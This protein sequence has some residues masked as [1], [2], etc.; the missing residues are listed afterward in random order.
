MIN[1]KELF[2]NAYPWQ[3]TMPVLEI[4][5]EPYE[6]GYEYG[7]QC[8]YIINN[9]SLKFINQ[10]AEI[11][12]V[13]I[14][15]LEDESLKYEKEIKSQI[16]EE[17]INEMK[18]IAAGADVDYLDILIL[19]CG[20][21][22]LNSLPTPET[23]PHYMCSSFS[24]YNE[25]TENSNLICG[26]NDDGGR[27]IDQFLVL[28]KVH[29]NNGNSFVAPVVPGYIGYHRMWNSKGTVIFGL[30]LENGCKNEVFDY[31][32]PMWV[33]HRYLIQYK[34][35]TGQ[36]AE[37]LKEFSPPTAFNFLVSD[38]KKEV[39]I[40]HVSA[41]KIVEYKPEETF[42][43]L[44]NHAL[45]DDIKPYV[46]LREHPSSTDYRY[47]T[48]FNHIQNNKGKINVDVG[49]SAL[50]SHNDSSNGK[51]IPSPNTP[52]SHHEY[53]NKMTGTV[54]SVVIELKE[55]R[56]EANVSLGNPC[57]N[58]WIKDILLYE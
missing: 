14:E 19:N 42:Y 38:S 36:I 51:I 54:S 15:K 35:N 8:K 13:S 1:W 7:Q 29:P 30:S 33:V 25:D 5:G 24:A 28:L 22:L 12:G 55:D 3:G 47:E 17:Y 56:L 23:H 34:D 40:C 39:K 45:N 2:Q 9:Y 18:G 50:S 43:V 41:N 16:G 10:L 49:K 53:N 31:N 11:T 21:D 58:R 26:H 46:I 20:W 48:V 27:F 4:S 52:C 37:G 57:E 32:I 44:T 6:M